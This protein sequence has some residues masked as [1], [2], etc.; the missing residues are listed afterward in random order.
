MNESLPIHPSPESA[1]AAPAAP[2]RPAG[3][4]RPGDEAAATR[5]ALWVMR[6][7][8]DAVIIAFILAMFI[9][10]FVVELFKIPSG[11]MTPTLI[12]GL[13]SWVD[14]N[15]DGKLDLLFFRDRWDNRPLLFLD[16]Q[17]RLAARGATSISEDEKLRLAENGMI[18]YQNDRILVNK[19]A[20]WF[21]PP[22]R[23]DIVVFNVPNRRVPDPLWSPD[24]AIYIK[25]CVGQPGDVLSFSGDDHLV[26]DGRRVE[27]PPFFSFQ[28]YQRAVP[29]NY[30]PLDE[31]S[32]GD[33][34]PGMRAIQRIH[35]PGNEIYV[36]GD[37]TFSS[38]D[39]RYWGGVPL[40]RLKGR[41]FFRYWPLRQMK[42]LG[43]N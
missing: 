26:A 27:R 25:R 30:D 15:Q 19:F 33:G 11:S 12:G 13:V 23:G 4:V 32:Y 24:K 6:E 29:R 34:G 3:A 17:G 35:V 37:N 31:I 18:G 28:A 42:F 8:L 5:G 41:A 36:F 43:A 7:W 20:Y 40:E 14:Y 9:R 10:I 22:R 16:E 38:L 39:S 1:T 21:H 2:A